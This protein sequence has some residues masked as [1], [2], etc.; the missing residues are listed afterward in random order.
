MTMTAATD[1]RHARTLARVLDS[2]FSIPG[3]R[4]RFGL[5]PI[6]GLIPGGGDVAGAALSGYIVLIAARL[7][8]PPAVL[9]RM[10]LNVLIDTVVGSVPLLGDLFDVAWKSNLRN[11]ALLERYAE[12]PVAVERRSRGLMVLVLF[13]LALIAAAVGVVSFLLVQALWRMLTS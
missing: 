3:T 6:L 7:G 4:I 2:A 5:D 8:A 12:R 11:V 10:L 1:V 9:G 13:G